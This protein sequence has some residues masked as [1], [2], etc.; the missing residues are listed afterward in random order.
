[1]LGH[2]KPN[3][4]RP[5][6]EQQMK[7]KNET[8]RRWYFQ[9]SLQPAWFLADSPTRRWSLLKATQDGIVRFHKSLGIISTRSF[10]G[11]HTPHTRMCS[12]QMDSCRC[13]SSFSFFS[14]PDMFF[15]YLSAPSHFWPSPPPLL[16]LF[17]FPLSLLLGKYSS[18]NIYKLQVQGV[19]LCIW[20]AVRMELCSNYQN[21]LG[22]LKLGKTEG[23]KMEN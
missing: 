7:V 18:F 23:D 22:R 5:K 20:G 8:N 4:V 3:N 19:S 12:L 2:G 16:L 10:S 6:L 9:H 11:C 14:L 13:P 21:S 17:S 1:M 15:L